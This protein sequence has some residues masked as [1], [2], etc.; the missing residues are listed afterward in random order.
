MQHNIPEI[1]ELLQ[2]QN[3]T[4]DMPTITCQLLTT[5]SAVGH[6]APMTKIIGNI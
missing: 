5:V 3:E 2:I 6:L 1:I 4:H